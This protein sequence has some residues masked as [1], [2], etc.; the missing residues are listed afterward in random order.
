MET[1]KFQG[2]EWSAPGLPHFA[3]AQGGT[4]AEAIA[5]LEAQHGARILAVGDTEVDIQ[6]FDGDDR[7]DPEALAQAAFLNSDD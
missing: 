6:D 3:S 4:E 7:M 5:A 1:Y 2:I